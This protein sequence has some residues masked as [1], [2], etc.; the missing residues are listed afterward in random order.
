MENINI[1]KEE[2]QL[3]E[4][5]FAETKIDLPDNGFTE[6]VMDNLTQTVRR[7]NYIWTVV[8]LLAAIILF[9]SSDGVNH[10]RVFATNVVKSLLSIQL[11]QINLQAIG[12]AAFIL[13]FLC[14]VNIEDNRS[15]L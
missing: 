11:E 4:H 14:I 12:A 5:F 13:L 1:N 8:C 9:L 7:R 3:L 6:R 10:V 2:E 15:I